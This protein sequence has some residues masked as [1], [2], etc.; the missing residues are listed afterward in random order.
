MRKKSEYKISSSVKDGILEI[1]LTGKLITSA[2]EELQIKI[3]DIVIERGINNLLVDARA[4]GGPRIGTIETYTTVR[5]PP[6]S[7][8]R[9][10]VAVVDRQENA[11]QGAFLETTALNAGHVLKFF[12]D[13]D[14]ARA[15]LKSK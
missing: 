3:A 1:V 9:V 12:T 11:K 2:V 5:R 7:I 10:T 4:M 8:P 14:A 6:P 15:W 13:I